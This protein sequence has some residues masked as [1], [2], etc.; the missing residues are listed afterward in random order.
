MASTSLWMDVDVFPEAEA[1]SDDVQCDVAIV[2]S[3]IAGLSTAYEVA[4]RDRSVIV[5][6]RGSIC[7]GMTAR[8]SAHLAPL[9]DDLMSEMKRLRGLELSRIFYQSQAAAVDRIEAIQ[10]QEGIDCDFRRLDGY[11]FQGNGMPADVLDEE[12]DVLTE[13]GA[14][15][16][17]IT[18]VPLLGTEKRPALRYPRQATFHPLKYLAGVAAACAQKGVRFFANSPV[19]D[20]HEENGAVTLRTERAVVR[21][22]YAVVATNASIADRVV[23]H[24]KTAPYRTYV[25]AF[26]LP[27]GALADALYWDTEDPYHYVRIQPAGKGAN[28]FLLVG[29]ED[30]KS[31]ES[32]DADERFRRLERWIKRFLPKLGPVTHRWSGQVLDTIDYAGFIGRNPGTEFTYVAAGDSGQGL[33]HGVM[34]AMLNAG[35]IVD[36]KSAWAECYAPDRVPFRAAR[37]FLTENVTAIRNFAEYALPGEIESADALKPGQGAIVREGLKKVAAYRDRQGELTLRSA[38]CTHVGCHLHWNSFEQCWDCP[39]HGSIFDTE[40]RPINAPAI[41]PLGIIK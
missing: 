1:L 5:I 11:L 27:K 9:C 17:R 21:A 25:L 18:S 16:D 22:A 15:V 19:L 37:N 14:P 10:K 3:G 12:L 29:G 26:A 30:H 34:G 6:D 39:C 8:T 41:A 13:I 20:V 33:T 36:G 24:T 40:G 7:G 23:L 2:G 32:D 38:T 31:G 35:L 4:Q 28:D